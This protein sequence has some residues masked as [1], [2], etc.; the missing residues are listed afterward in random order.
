MTTTKK[1]TK[2]KAPE[3]APPLSNQPA[4]SGVHMWVYAN[5]PPDQQFILANGERMKNLFELAEKLSS[6]DGQLFSS[7]VNSERN[8]FANWVEYVFGEKELAHKFKQSQ[9]A[10]RHEIH[11]LK[12]MLGRVLSDDKHQHK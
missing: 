8:D 7:H 2:K 3:V 6:M 11:L 4:V 5:C 10:E 12:H 1:Q 9:S